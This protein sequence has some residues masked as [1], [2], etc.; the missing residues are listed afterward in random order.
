MATLAQTG[1]ARIR[2][3]AETMPPPA[4]R[5]P[6]YWDTAC[7][8][9]AACDPQLGALIARYPGAT[10]TSHGDAFYT[11]ARA[12]VGQQISVRAADAVWQRL[13]SRLGTIAPAQVLTTSADDL[14]GSGLSW[15]KTEYLHDLAAHFADGRLGHALFAT[16]GDDELLA[17]LTTVRGIGRWSAEMFLIFHLMRPDVLPLDDIGL[18]RAIGLHY[19]DGARVGAREARQI[20]AAWAPWRSVATWYL[21]RALDPVPVAY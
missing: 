9:L 14:R 4:A 15:R 2:H 11:L 13:E 6:E 1:A 10:L 7:R 8:Q 12:I 3:L 20:A 18:L 19:R 5:H 16:A 17:R 21:W